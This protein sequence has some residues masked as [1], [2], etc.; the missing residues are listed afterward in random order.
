MGSAPYFAGDVKASVSL[1]SFYDNFDMA[2]GKVTNAEIDTKL[3][4]AVETLIK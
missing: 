4:E 1:P 2:T 3:K